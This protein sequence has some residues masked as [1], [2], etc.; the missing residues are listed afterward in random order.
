MSW[1][2]RHSLSEYCL[3]EC[4]LL[5]SYQ[6]RPDLS[7]LA[8][9][10]AG[11]PHALYSAGS[12]RNLD[13]YLIDEQEVDGF[14]LMQA[15]ARSAFRQLL[16]RWPQCRRVLVLCGVGNNSGDG[17]LLATCALRHGLDVI[18]LM[19]ADSAKL[20]GDVRK[21]WQRAS[22]QKISMVTAAQSTD[23][24]LTSL[25]EQADVTVDAMLGTGLNGAP[26]GEFARVIALCNQSAAGVL[27]LDVPSGLNATT[28]AAAGDVVAADAT[29]TFI[30]LKAGL[31]TGHGPAVCGEVVFEDLGVA[32]QLDGCTEP[33]L[34]TRADW[35]SVTLGISKR[36]ANAHRGNFG[37]VLVV[38]GDRGF[39]GAGL[40]AA[41][42]AAR[43]GA[44]LVS[45]ATRQEHVVAALNRCPSVMSHGVVHGTELAPLLAAATVVV[46][47]PGL[48]QSAWGQQ[49]LQQVLECNKPQVLDAD[50][51]NLMADGLVANKALAAADSCILTPHPGEAARL[52]GCTVAEVEIDRLSA[53]RTLQSRYGCAILL[54]GAGT[55]IATM[56]GQ[57]FVVS[58]SNPGLATGGMGDVLAGIAGGL[59]AQLTS[60]TQAVVTAAALHLAAADMATQQFGYMGLQPTDVIDALPRV[61]ACSGR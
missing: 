50:A 36:A 54:K 1:S 59:L 33:V 39:G 35:F 29:V 46:W 30:G 52:L 34:A 44:G 2:T 48:G 14:E 5:G 40:L 9:H 53:A 8:G 21:T 17:Y 7:A 55:V 15:A 20:Q 56:H 58:G 24:D 41:E 27:A 47:G 19:L 3:S 45:L 22:D 25:L 23:T 49:M 37:H 57:V 10:G 38:A 42:A 12:V 51:L 13:R 31:F 60:S 16:R 6:S 26:R 4:R 61:L 28:G 43:S 18:C 11:L 32:S